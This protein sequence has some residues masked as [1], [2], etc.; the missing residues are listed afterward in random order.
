MSRCSDRAETVQGAHYSAERESSE[1][2]CFLTEANWETGDSLC[3]VGLIKVDLWKNHLQ[4]VASDFAWV[5]PT[6]QRQR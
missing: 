2:L 3:A 5:W 1:E 4:G 6:V